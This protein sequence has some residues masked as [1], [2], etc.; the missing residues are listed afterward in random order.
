MTAVKELKTEWGERLEKD[1][2]FEEYPRPLMQRNSYVNLNGEWDY[3]MTGQEQELS[4]L[5]WEG[6]IL[7]PF[8]PEASLSGVG[9]QLQ[10]G[11]Y[12]W[13]RRTFKVPDEYSSSKHLILHFGAVDQ[14][15]KVYVNQKL[16]TA[17][18]GGY[19][20]FEADITE[21]LLTETAAGEDNEIIVCV[22]DDS[23]TSYYS[24]GK[25]MLKRGGMFYTAQSGIWQ[26]VWLECVAENY[27]KDVLCKP[28]ANLGEVSFEVKIQTMAGVEKNT[29]GAVDTACIEKLQVEIYAACIDAQFGVSSEVFKSVNDSAG[30]GSARSDKD[31]AEKQRIIYAGP[32][33]KSIKIECAEKKLWTPDTPYL[34]YYKLTYGED[35]V[36]G[37][38]AFRTFTV[39]PDEKGVMRMCLNH[40]PYFQ[41]GVLDQGYW[42]DG[43]YTAP[44]D[45]ALIYDIVKMKELGFN[46]L[47]KHI[48]IE[49]QR[50]YYH[51]DR[52][53]MVVW[54]DMINGGGKYRFW[55][56]TYLATLFNMFNYRIKDN[57]YGLLARRDERGKKQFETEMEQTVKALTAHPSIG[58]WVIFNEGWGQFDAVRMTKRL[59][60]LDSSRVIDSTSGWFDQKCGDLRSQHYYFFKLVLVWDKMR[61]IVLSELGGF[62]Y[63]V[64]GH[65]C[66]AKV[67]GYH[68]CRTLKEL[69]Q[70]YEKLMRDTIEPEI[71]NGLSA[72]VYTQLSDVEEEVN[73]ILTYDREV[74]KFEEMR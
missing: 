64:E 28:D 69:H 11:E 43:L 10:P 41:K 47:R 62:P 6:K 14:R 40:Q 61:A 9:R 68:P 1:R 3:C 22:R 67:Y 63:R 30:A 7:V 12:L 45:N 46:M 59:R 25:Q 49:P 13:Y 66:C 42:P 48:K 5:P 36:T 54:Q 8:S 56:V 26:T 17:H 52:L 73:G 38:F 24:R 21:A 55:F 50:W 65:S 44:C 74:C 32:M 60:E 58:T 19:L 33:Q 29:E 70:A 53:G 15:C 39:E 71:A 18:I 23:D 31:R 16:V 4:K 20:P 2:I 35:E 57:C 72:T 27:L 51:C 34:Y 37:Y